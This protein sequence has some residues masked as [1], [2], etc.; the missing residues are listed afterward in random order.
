MFGGKRWLAGQNGGHLAT[1]FPQRPMSFRAYNLPIRSLFLV[2][3]V[4]ISI[5][6]MSS[7]SWKDPILHLRMFPRRSCRARLYV[8]FRHPLHLPCFGA[9]I[10]AFEYVPAKQ[11]WPPKLIELGSSKAFNM[12]IPCHY[13]ICCCMK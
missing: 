2:N 3:H 13:S 1:L 5:V 9:Y 10:Y 6:S 12:V 8:W 11:G 4:S 7:A